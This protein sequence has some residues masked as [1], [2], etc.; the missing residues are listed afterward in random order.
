MASRADWLFTIVL[1]VSLVVFLGGLYGQT[2]I[3]GYVKPK[4]SMNP[5]EI[6]KSFI[7]LSSMS[8]GYEFLNFLVLALIAVVVYIL[9]TMLK[10]W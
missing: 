8:A 6:I 5:V 10:F 2:V 4:F 9:F 3:K 1:F 7:S